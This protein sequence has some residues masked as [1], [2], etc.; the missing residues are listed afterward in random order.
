MYPTQTIDLCMY[1][2]PDNMRRIHDYIISKSV[3][4]EID[5]RWPLRGQRKL[6]DIPA[7]LSLWLSNRNAYDV[8]K[9]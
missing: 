3:S 4:M 6:E 8:A 1:N 9:W 2:F 5:V 7:S